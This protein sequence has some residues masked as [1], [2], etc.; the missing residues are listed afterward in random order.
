M[1]PPPTFHVKQW[2]S[3]T[4]SGGI[5]A[6]TGVKAGGAMD[7]GHG[8][9]T[10]M[11]DAVAAGAAGAKGHL[12]A[13][14]VG[15]P[16][17][18]TDG[19]P[20]ASPAAVPPLAPKTQFSVKGTAF[21][22]E[23]RY[24]FVKALGLGAYGVVC[25]VADS[26][27]GKKVAVKKVSGVFDDLTDAKRIIREIR[28]LGQM[29]HE[30]ILAVLDM[31]EPADY[32]TF[33][34]V[35]IVTELMD[36][37]LNKLLRS[38]HPLLEAQC[39]YFGY[40]LLRALLYI[41][42]VNI[43]HRDIKPANVLVNENC[44]VKLCDFG[45]ARYI[46]PE[47]ASAMTEYVVTRWYRAPELLL[48][49]DDYT[50]AI[51]MWS[52]GCLLAESM[53]RKPLFPGKDVKH[54]VEL[55]CRVTGKPTEEEIGA[56]SNRQARDFLRKL[57]AFPR[58]DFAKLLPGVDAAGVDLIEKLL[59]FDPRRR[60][61]AAAALAHPYLAEY[62]DEESERVAN[63]TLDLNELEPP[64]EKKLGKEGI[65]ALMWAEICR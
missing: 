64:S 40:Q 44:D 21:C 51:D 55:T 13:A 39:K 11:V 45:L 36:T 60:L 17:S 30:N 28:L 27:T 2:L 38:K 25:A 24:S 16:M 65:R 41:H 29:N 4:K 59:V 19:T 6:A 8:R 63:H 18:A 9:D 57:P 20:A 15:S 7:A 46:D 50:S 54:Q 3:R 31:D 32:T 12:A 61:T 62:R 35:Y 14:L 34:D 58:T 56:I 26:V 42:S 47:N 48:A 53:T 43:I 22:V 52:F 10:D 33:N 1:V 37:D 23:N 49:D 5:A